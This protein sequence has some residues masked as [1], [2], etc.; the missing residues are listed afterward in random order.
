MER[1]GHA[2]LGKGRLELLEGIDRWRSISAAA[3]QIGMSYRRAWLLVQSIN[4]AAGEPLVEAAVG[5]TRGGGARLTP[6]GQIAMTTFR[7]LQRTVIHTAG[8][9]LQQLLAGPATESIH[10]VAA[11]SLEEVLGQLLADYALQQPAVR[12]RAVYGGSDELADHLLSGAAGELFLTAGEEQL[13]RLQQAGLATPGGRVPL[14]DNTLAIIGPADRLV[15]VK[16]PKDLLG[17]DISR[18]AVA[19]PSCP[20][21]KYTQECLNTLG[22]YRRLQERVI[23]VDNSR[24]VLAAVRAGQADAGLVYGSDATTAAGCRL[25]YR[26]RR[27]ERPIRYWAGIIGRHENGSGVRALLQF[28]T[29]PQAAH[30]FRQCGFALPT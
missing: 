17:R 2:M 9:A 4:E 16:K 22:I 18:V 10:V 13:D 27:S 26:F 28:L 24:A 11:A 23:F 5:G 29:S 15:S 19:Q 6:R 25:L 12:V 1:R 30:R 3:R 7:T 14:A 20:L 21:G 8:S